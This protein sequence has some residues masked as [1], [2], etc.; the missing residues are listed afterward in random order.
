MDATK[1]FPLR[2]VLSVTTGRLFTKPRG[3]D[4]NGIGDLYDILNWMTG[5]NLL[6]HQ[7][8]RAARQCT[9]LLLETFPFLAK[10]KDKLP[11]L[12]QDLELART[13]WS[14]ERRKADAAEFVEAWLVKFGDMVGLQHLWLDVP[15]LPKYTPWEP[16]D[17]LRTMIGER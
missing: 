10:A 17:E 2:V 14:D 7:L 6:T 5:D 12:D 11:I 16:L 3:L 4:D 1:R 9:P 8:P 15:K 13:A